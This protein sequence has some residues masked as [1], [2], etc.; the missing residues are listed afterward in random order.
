MFSITYR[1]TGDFYVAF[2]SQLT[3]DLQGFQLARGYSTR[4]GLTKSYDRSI[5]LASASIYD[6]CRTS[7]ILRSP[8]PCA[9][10][11]EEGKRL[12]TKDPLIGKTDRFAVDRFFDVRS[13]L[14]SRLPVI[15]GLENFSR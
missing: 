12:S 9:P 11:L 7:E 8:W 3:F 13:S 2:M 10:R 6:R 15:D 1:Q 5:G 14:S 4:H